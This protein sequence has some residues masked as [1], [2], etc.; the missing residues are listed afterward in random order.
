MTFFDAG[1]LTALEQVDKAQY[2]D[3]RVEGRVGHRM[4]HV[5]L[6]GVMAQDVRFDLLDQLSGFG[7]AG[8]IDLVQRRFG[9]DVG[10]LAGREVVEDRTSWPR[11]T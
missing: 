11:S 4:A 5:H 1:V 2:V 8:D 7:I 10:A 6:R 9:V 3:P